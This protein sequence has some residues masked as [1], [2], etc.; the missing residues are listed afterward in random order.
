MLHEI[1]LSLSGHPSPLLTADHSSPTSILSPP[2]KALLSS[3]AHLSD[4]HSK[5]LAH[6][7]TIAS[8]HPSSICQAVAT[9]ISAVHLAAFQRK[10]LEVEDGILRKDAGSVGAYNIVPLTAIVGEFSGWTRGMEWFLEIVEFMMRGSG[11]KKCTGAMIIDRLCDAM[12]TGYVDI[13]EAALSLVKAAE[14]A[15]LKQVSAWILYGRLPSFGRE[16]FFVQP[17]PDDI[18]VGSGLPEKGS[19]TE[20]PQDY[21]SKRELLPAFVSASTASSLIFIGRSL[22]HIRVKGISS[23]SSPELDLLSSHLR[24]LSTLKF[25]INSASFSRVIS[26]IRLSLSQTTLQKLCFENSSY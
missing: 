16:D 22:N 11:E 7:A 21:Q 14:T 6:T 10:V 4:L 13:E 9:T 24:Q 5:L 8:T 2:E 17:A 25:P 23:A 19:S 18:E 26:S 20:T 12:Q 3:V 1:L 15:W